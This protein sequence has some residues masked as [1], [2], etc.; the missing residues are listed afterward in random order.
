MIF[1]ESETVELKREYVD[2][3]RKEIIAM[4]NCTG[5]T[6]YIGVEDDGTIAGVDDCDFTIQRIVN[7][8]RDAV[9]PD[10]TM[11]LHYDVLT[12][13]GKNIVKVTVQ[14]GTNRPYYLASKGLR[15]E[16]VY[17]RQGTSSVPASDAAIRRM[18][19]ETD[20]DNY[21]DMRSLNQQLTFEE[22]SKR[23]KQQQ[24][25]FGVQQMRTLGLISADGL[26][27][28]LGLLLS[29]Q[30]PHIIKAATFNGIDQQEFQ[31]RREFGG[32]LLKQVDDAYDYLDMRNKTH[33]AFEG[34]YRQDRKDYPETALRE[35]LLNAVVHRDYAFSAGTLIGVYSDRIEIVSI[36]GLVHDV[37][38]DD[39]L[40]GLSV[41]RN[42]KL[43]NVF[44]RLKLIEAYGTGMRKMRMAYRDDTQEPSFQVTSNAFKVILPRQTTENERQTDTTDERSDRIIR[45]LQE[46]GSMTRRDAETE[47][48][49]KQ[50]MAIR[51]LKDMVERK[52][53]RTVGKGKN[54]R[55]E[56]TDSGHNR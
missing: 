44:Y 18:I 25:D 8:I 22:A 53:I 34:L 21:E 36:G 14:T 20:G 30:C 1:R 42:A 37:S 13:D 50:A 15:P 41:C 35:A 23:F 45:Y 27:T 55:Y 2:E 46:K 17:V 7:G 32:S 48:D 12:L 38:L 39:V 11:F 6:L 49:I 3:I 43:A 5:G 33:A 31:D 10:L 9:K 29:D 28:N 26:F 19:K 24:I 54:T 52:L 56:L 16:G 4:T 51:T 47:L 40:I